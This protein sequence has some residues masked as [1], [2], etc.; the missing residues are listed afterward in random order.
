MDWPYLINV[1]II[2]LKDCT[3]ER[4][5]NHMSPCSSSQLPTSLS[6]VVRIV[7]SSM[8]VTGAY[9]N[10]YSDHVLCETSS[11]MIFQ[12]VTCHGSQNTQW[13]LSR[14][15][16]LSMI[17]QRHPSTTSPIKN[18]TSSYQNLEILLMGINFLQFIGNFYL[19]C[20]QIPKTTSV[21]VD[22]KWF[23]SSPFVIFNKERNS[24][25]P[26]SLSFTKLRRMLP[27][28]INPI[29]LLRNETMTEIYCDIKESNIIY[30]AQVVA[31]R[32]E[33]NVILNWI[34]R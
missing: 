26:I 13:I 1:W 12:P 18:V 10:L 21:R 15:D 22:L 23:R 7:Y 32:S 20:G 14:L 24:F 16:N 30:E 19:M 6:F 34:F 28:K 27:A 31:N 9:P 2:L 25:L 11:I 17:I 33:V 29:L 4:F 8:D 3:P 5:T